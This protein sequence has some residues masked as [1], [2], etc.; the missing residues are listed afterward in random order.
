MN[1]VCDC[2]NHWF[3]SM[4]TV[5]LCANREVVYEHMYL[6]SRKFNRMIK[7]FDCR[8]RIYV[9]LP[10]REFSLSSTYIIAVTIISFKGS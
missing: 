7:G 3:F 8:T 2:S 10:I 6:N 5:E 4:V 1:R 9:T